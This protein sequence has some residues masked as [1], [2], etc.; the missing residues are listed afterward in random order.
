MNIKVLNKW[1]RWLVLLLFLEL[2]GIHLALDEHKVFAED[3]FYSGTSYSDIDLRRWMTNTIED[4]KPIS[5]LSVPG[6]HDSATYQIN[7]IYNMAEGVVRTQS[8]E[9]DIPS[10]LNAGIRYLD[11]RVAED[12]SMHHGVAWVGESFSI[13]M[14]EIK[15]FLIKNPGEFVFVRVKNENFSYSNNWQK[16]LAFKEKLLKVL[17]GEVGT[18]YLFYGSNS[19]KVK[20]TRGK[21]I[22]ID[23]TENNLLSDISNYPYNSFILNIQDKFENVNAEEKLALI[24]ATAS[25]ANWEQSRLTI[26]HVSYT[27]ANIYRLASEM[28]VKVFNWLKNDGQNDD[29][30]GIMPMDFPS[31]ELVRQVVFQ[32]Q[33]TSEVY[34]LLEQWERQIGYFYD[35]ADKNEDGLID[36]NEL[37]DAKALYN[38]VA[39][40]RQKLLENVAKVNS[41]VVKERLKS[42]M[43]QLEM[44]MPSE[45]VDQV[46]PIKNLIQLAKEKVSIANS[47]LEE[48]RGQ[49]AVSDATYSQW[50]VLKNEASQAMIQAKEAIDTLSVGTGRNQL[51]DELKMNRIESPLIATLSFADSYKVYD[52]QNMIFSTSSLCLNYK[53]EVQPISL[54][55]EDVTL[56]SDS[57]ILDKNTI[58]DVGTY[59]MSL[60]PSAWE[61]VAQEAKGKGWLVLTDSNIVANYTVSPRKVTV[62]AENQNLSISNLTEKLPIAYKSTDEVFK[63]DVNENRLE[64]VNSLAN[65]FNQMN[66]TVGHTYSEALQVRVI[67]EASKNYE[68]TY[69]PGNLTVIESEDQS[70]SSIEVIE[71][72]LYLDNSLLF[73]GLLVIMLMFSSMFIVFL[74][75]RKYDLI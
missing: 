18:P 28:N 3:N 65:D 72:G 19:P 67:G 37:E 17:V 33:R 41:Q 38:Q 34:Q 24:K 15:D 57:T 6:T 20:E 44:K 68:F 49:G 25:V 43:N 2:L 40:M 29:I 48:L 9:M 7:G 53:Q 70:S 61:K 14:R 23:D 4:S 62:I 51:Y 55:A 54:T 16:M 13:H 31:E 30:L 47:K 73:Y 36:I 60:N 42:E 10:Q 27:G 8:K 1:L 58:V 11:M 45:P 39:E 26:N 21:I 64:V 46:T 32:N 22:L 12:L 74:I 63:N 66:A 5:I 71:T 35:Y 69:I 75:I 59:K 56:Q 52:G 50:F